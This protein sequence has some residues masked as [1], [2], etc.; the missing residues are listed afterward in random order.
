MPEDGPSHEA[1]GG[2]QAGS[3]TLSCVSCRNRKLKCDRTKPR[4]KRCEKANLECVFPESRRRP[5]F[6]RRNV[7]EL[8][9]RLAQV[10]VLLKEA[11]QN[12][13]RSLHG[14]AAEHAEFQSTEAS[15][16]E[17][18]I[19]EGLDFTAPDLS[20]DDGAQF[21][22]QQ[23][24]TTTFSPGNLGG[25][26][27]GSTPFNGSLIDLGGVYERLPP[28]EVMEDLNRIFFAT[29][30]YLIPIIHPSRYLQA[31]YS[32]PHMKPP[33]CLQYIIWALA[34]HG[35][36]KYNMY[37]DIFYRRSRQY[38]D[39]DE[40][41]SYGEHFITVAH[42]QAY[43]VMATYE[44]KTMMFTRAAMTCAKAVRLVEMMG[45]H[46]LDGAAEEI[47]PTLLP[48]KDW[49]ELE[50][51]RRTFWG[52]FC[53]DSHCSI[54]T[55][56]PFLIDT[57]EVT[58]ML[59]TSEYAFEN[60][61]KEE[62][63]SIHEAFKGQPYSSF[64]G[65]VLICHIHN[66]ILKHVHKPKPTDNPD[67]YEFGEYWQ[68]HRDLDN[69]LS[70]AF[71]YLPQSFRLPENY[72]D[73]I[74]LH[75]NLNLHA[76]IIC[77]HHS[78]IERIDA[79]K[80]P[81][82]VKKACQDRLTTAAQEIV[83]IIKLT[84]HVNTSPRSPLTALSMYCAASVYIYFCKE[85]Q[86][87]T[88]LDNLD[89]II[90]AME[91]LG[92]DHS[93]TRAFLR[94]VVVDIER[95]DI[96]N[97]VRLPRL[98]HLNDEFGTQISHNIPLLARSSVSRHSQVQPPLP[99]RL[100]LGNP[101][102]QP[103]DD[104]H[105]HGECGTWTSEIHV[106]SKASQE[107][108]PFEAT[109]SGSKFKRKRVSPLD[110]TGRAHDSPDGNGSSWTAPGTSTNPSAHSSPAN[111]TT[112]AHPMNCG[113]GYATSPHVEFNLPHRTGSPH[114]SAN[115][116]FKAPASAVWSG[117]GVGC[118]MPAAFRPAA[119]GAPSWLDAKGRDCDLARGYMQ[120]VFAGPG[121]IPSG[122]SAPEPNPEPS[123]P[124][125]QTQNPIPQNQ[126]GHDDAGIPWDLSGTEGMDMNV[127]TNV[128]WGILSAAIGVDLPAAMNF[129]GGRGDGETR[130]GAG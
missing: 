26:D 123:F 129:S 6:K 41:K 5:A 38:T 118:S 22:F 57:S 64:A 66:Q 103:L 91:A 110:E 33:M 119:R 81:D 51:R 24:P 120:A 90:S 55:G 46:R 124:T 4:C 101:V 9:A 115:P 130:S 19:F 105:C 100:P 80:L 102:G 7:K 86:A 71:M 99:G 62:T 104:E 42:A 27:Q 121:F 68:R 78:A 87:P 36:P 32:A 67:N 21:A 117:M 111:M 112:P 60:G 16:T 39:A 45:L 50:E 113:G 44:A 85:N 37:H 74:A 11:G 97:I 75:T 92:R 88:N 116:E 77:L 83:N 23:E 109:Q 94:Q 58:T 96:K 82:S 84:S 48:P 43:C 65:A 8:E 54:S 52:V 28:F 69:T 125:A 114:V 127:N 70:S 89:F 18:I 93:I 47:S 63:Y 72:R 56:W 126:T 108:M 95:N 29:Q 76:S 14:K 107:P 98:D 20:Y 79:Y 2:G 1:P 40:M 25:Q 10:E 12:G 128:E 106:Y 30:K 17:N 15:G 3:E 49:A 34:A 59:P 35:H 122:P 13:S 61:E 31:F 53:I 73:P